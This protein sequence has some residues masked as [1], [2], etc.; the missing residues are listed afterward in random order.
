MVTHPPRHV[1]IPAYRH[2]F[3]LREYLNDAAA[4]RRANRHVHCLRDARTV[5]S[6]NETGAI[7]QPYLLL[8]C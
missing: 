6:Y 3:A 7:H 5:H 4:V 8:E 2:K 1:P